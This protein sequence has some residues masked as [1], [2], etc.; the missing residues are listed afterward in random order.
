M[1]LLHPWMLLLLLILVPLI[2]WYIMKWRNSNPSMGVSSVS[3]FIPYRATLKVWMMHLCFVLQ[4]VAIGALI[5]ALARPQSHDSLRSSSIEGTDIVLALDISSSM[6]ATDLQPNRIQAAKDVASK[7]VSNRPDD[8]IG[9]VAFSGES[10]S[11]MPL[12]TDKAALVNAIANTKTGDLNDG[13]AIGDGIA[14]SINRLVS[15]Q[16]KSKSIIL[17]TDGTNNSGDVAPATAAQIAK[18]KGIRIYAIGVG[19][20]GSINITDPYGFST[21]TM[22]TKI[23]ESALKN[24]ASTTGGK[25]F[26]ATD[27]RMLRQVFEEIDSLE[28]SRINVNNFTQTEENFMPW[29]LVALCAMAAYLTLRYTLLRR[30]P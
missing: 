18:Q 24:I 29:I 3:S 16:A 9:L 25:F 8:N 17:L 13:T 12:T 11:L 27:S 28:K 22:E 19:T 26:R 10:L 20:N 4:L 5:V 30:I 2:I 6:L 7:F 1:S 14:S 23:D 15:G 21:T